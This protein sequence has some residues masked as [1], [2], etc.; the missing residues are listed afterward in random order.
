MKRWLGPSL[1]R[2]TVFALLTAM[3]LVWAVL[4]AKDFWAFKQDV[5]DRASFGRIAQAT[6][7][8]LQGFEAEQAGWAMAAADRQYNELRRQAEPQA[9]GTLLFRLNAADG[10]LVYQ[11]EGGVPQAGRLATDPLREVEY[12]GLRY[13]PMVQVN[14]NWHFAVW[15]PVMTDATAMGLIGKDILS[16][17]LVALPFVLLP[18]G[19][20]VWLGLRPLRMLSQQIARRPPDDLSPLQEP[21]GYAE[22][23]PLVEAANVLLERS[24]RQRALEQSFV[25]DAAHELKTPLAVVAAQA[26]VLATAPDE[27][28]RKVALQALE[29]GVN[30]ASHQ[31]TQLLS[32]AALE[33]AAP[34][35]AQV[36]DLVALAREVLIELEPLAREKGTALALQSPD[37]LMDRLD[38][39]ALRLVLLNLVRNAIQHGGPGGEVEMQLSLEHGML[40]LAVCDDGP[41]ILPADRER[42]FDR[43]FRSES[44]HTSGSGLGLSI[45]K[46][47][48]QRMKAEVT[49]ADNP[50][51]HGAL[52]QLKWAPSSAS[53][54]CF[55]P[56]SRV[57]P[58]A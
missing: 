56:V 7:A 57:A 41:G 43:F 8:S 29:Q 39:D 25:Q 22:L 55:G 37:R 32:L 12:L 24:R 3:V 45:V 27:A 11:S 51:A 58:H 2:R 46:R 18:I 14:A 26:H 1:L 28:H 30:R 36:V 34:R 20:A 17:L 4:S 52:F 38:A 13:W 44:N 50:N 42:I 15:V 16:Y 53:E 40:C 31:V 23:V 35:P 49:V 19:L 9:L 54:E 21:T 47:A 48:A 10:S 5:R 33:H 6:L